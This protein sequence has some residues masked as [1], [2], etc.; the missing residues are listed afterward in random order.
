MDLGCL[1]SLPA[2]PERAVCMIGD[3]IP[4]D[5]RFYIATGTIEF[6]FTPTGPVMYLWD[7]ERGTPVPC[8]GPIV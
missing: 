7:K 6:Y 5:T 2:P 1:Y 3:A 4:A 8:F